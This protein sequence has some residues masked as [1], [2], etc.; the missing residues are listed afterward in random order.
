MFS[1]RAIE[2]CCSYPSS[3]AVIHYHVVEKARRSR[4]I[5]YKARD[6]F[7]QAINTTFKRRGDNGLPVWEKPE[8][9]GAPRDIYA[10]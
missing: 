5:A 10:A 2:T 9:P 8:A 6:C 4:K 7:F 1:C 3:P